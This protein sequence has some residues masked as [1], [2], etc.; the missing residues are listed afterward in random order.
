MKKLLL[1]L[2]W[3]CHAAAFAA[4][5]KISALPAASSIASTDTGVVVQGGATKKFAIS[6]LNTTA[7]GGTGLTAAVTGLMIGNGTIYGAYTGTSCTNQFVRSLSVAG[8]AT[9]ATVASTDVSSVTGTGAFVLATTPTLVTPVLG[10]ATGTSI[11]VSSYLQAGSTTPLTLT[12]GSIGMTK[13]TASGTAPG[14]AG[15]KF[16]VVCGTN[17][18]TAKLTMSAGT[19]ATPVTIVDNVGAAVT[20]C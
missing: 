5:I 8:V 12:A 17:A 6:L 11:A 3:M 14:A 2:F 1:I 18:G 9:C 4:D 20:G 15:V 7:N 16:E 19:S 13:I 10:V